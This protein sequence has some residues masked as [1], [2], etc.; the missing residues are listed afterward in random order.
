MEPSE[1]RVFYSGNWHG[2]YPVAERGEG[3]YL[4]DAEGKRYLDA[5]GG[6]F[7]VTIGHGVAEVAD[8]IADQA[9]KLSFVNRYRFTNEPQERLA[10]KIIEMAP[11]GMGEVFFI[12]SG[13]T[14]NETAIQIARQYHIERGNES[15]YKVIGQWHNYNGSTIGT[16]SLSGYVAPR[17][18]MK[19]DPYLLNFPLIQP[20]HCY[21]CPFNLTYPS[22]EVACA[23]ELARIIEQEGPDTISAFLATPIIGGTDGAIVPPPDYFAKIKEICEFYDILFIADEVI[24]GFGRLGKNF[25]I[26]H[27]HV[28][29]DIITTAKTLSSG[30]AP[31]AAVIVHKHILETFKS[32]NRKGILLFSTYSGHPLSCAAALA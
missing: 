8:A 32:G 9:R 23:N 4:Y 14:A 6:M 30:Y 25:G 21:H 19:M 28:T 2:S 3:A 26:Q 20:P 1:S 15:K 27:W 24:T 7:V 17:R 18:A 16:L 29:P 10:D 22:C 5:I 13:S 31:L 11:E 12:T